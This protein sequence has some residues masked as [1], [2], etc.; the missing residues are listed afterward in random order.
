MKNNKW[1]TFINKIKAMKLKKTNIK[2]PN[3][4][5]KSDYFTSARS[6]ADDIY[7]A[8]L[9]SRNRYKIAFF[10]MIGLTCLLTLC[11]I[12]L[13]PAQHTE[14]VVVHEGQGGYIWLSTT[15]A[16]H[17]LS[18]NWNRT[19]AEI[20]HYVQTREGYDPLLYNYQ[21]DEV[22]LFSTPQVLG[23]YE[24]AQSSDNANSPI[25][26]LSDKGYRTVEINSILPLDQAAQDENNSKN[27]HINLAQVNFVV[28]DHFFGSNQTVTNPY[29]ALVSWEYQSVNSDPDTLLQNWDGFTITKY[30]VQS[31]YHPTSSEES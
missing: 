10:T 5:N 1:I 28:V 16:S 17:T 14:L 20:A 8:T 3:S 15:K 13:V 25:R 26:T 7:T 9:I 12:M 27:K 24:L 19:A 11:V 23:E 30:V 22:K 4:D 2:N 31:V 21:T 6:W 29:T 18:T